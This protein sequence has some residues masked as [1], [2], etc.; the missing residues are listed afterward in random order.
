[1]EDILLSWWDVN[2]YCRRKDVLLVDLRNRNDYEKN[3]I[4]GAMQ[5]EYESIEQWLMQQEEAYKLIFYCDYGNQS[6]KAARFAREKG[7]EA[8]SVSGGIH[9]RNLA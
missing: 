6:I 5:V 9:G 4:E 3:H 8:Y 7:W 1:M 2:K